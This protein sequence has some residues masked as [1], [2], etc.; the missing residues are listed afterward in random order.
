MGIPSVIYGYL[1]LTI[2]IPFLR[3]VTEALMGDGLLAASLVLTLMVLPTITRISDDAI[4]TVP[5]YLK[6]GSYALGATR[7]QTIFRIILPAAKT[8]ILTASILEKFFCGYIFKN[9]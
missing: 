2:L 5:E 8:G 3:D 6:E 9:K 7:F 1:G 4:S